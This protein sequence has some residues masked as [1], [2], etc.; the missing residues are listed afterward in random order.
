MRVT[1]GLVA[2]ALIATPL[3]ANEALP[4]RPL[5]SYPHT[6]ALDLVEPQVGVP[7]ADPYRWLENDVRTDGEVA[8]WVAD[9]NRITSDYLAQLPGRAVFAARMKSLFNY[10]RFGV[11]R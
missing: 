4:E 5:P 2:I 9:Q 11:P 6:R 7:V 10:E 1:A 8:K 3:I